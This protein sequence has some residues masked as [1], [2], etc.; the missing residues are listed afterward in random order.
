MGV[1]RDFRRQSA[2]RKLTEDFVV[3]GNLTACN[4]GHA[5]PAAITKPNRSNELQEIAPGSAQRHVEAWVWG[6][7]RETKLLKIS[8]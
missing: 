8:R 3:F 6:M 1:A 4:R 7:V 5:G 2:C